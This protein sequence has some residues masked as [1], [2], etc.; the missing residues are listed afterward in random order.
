MKPPAQGS[1]SISL[2][3]FRVGRGSHSRRKASV[4]ASTAF[5]HV[6]S[7]ILFSPIPRSTGERVG[8][9][10]V[11]WL[12]IIVLFCVDCV[13]G[14]AGVRRAGG[15]TRLWVSRARGKGTRARGRGV[16]V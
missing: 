9:V 10:R 2:G 15:D 7:S 12:I 11:R 3:N 14:N 16:G 6:S 5:V 8:D 13:V 4:S 1:D